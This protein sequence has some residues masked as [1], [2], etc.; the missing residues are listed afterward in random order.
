MTPAF[1]RR[2]GASS[3]RGARRPT[4]RGAPDSAP[5]G[6]PF[7]LVLLDTNLLLLPFQQGFPLLEALG[8]W[9]PPSA[10]RVPTAVKGE[11]ERLERRGVPGAGGALELST[12]L[13]PIASRAGGDGGLLELARRERAVVATAD[14]RLRRRLTDAGVP[15]LF[16]RGGNRVEL[17]P[18]RPVGRLQLREKPSSIPTRRSRSG[19]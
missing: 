12:R 19:R 5:P 17:E 1:A 6:P 2:T 14:Q 10:L 4:D 11:L 8:R 18:G 7:L 9:S 16:P 3:G 13:K 15:V